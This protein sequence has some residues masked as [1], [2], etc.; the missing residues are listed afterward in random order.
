MINYIWSRPP[1]LK[2]SREILFAIKLVMEPLNLL[3]RSGG[4]Q[5]CFATIKHINILS[6]TWQ[7]KLLRN[8]R[9]WLQV[10]AHST[11]DNSTNKHAKQE[12]DL[13]LRNITYIAQMSKAQILDTT[14]NQTM[15]KWC[16]Q[17]GSITGSQTRDSVIEINTCHIK[18]STNSS[19]NW[20]WSDLSIL[21]ARRK[22][23]TPG[24]GDEGFPINVRKAFLVST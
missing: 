23:A 20:V 15:L 9:F 10:G 4:G 12:I 6:Y 11:H 5:T 21:L 16:L 7:L 24:G 2:S 19:Y 22:L 13:I 17:F 14:I 3:E 18:L 1:P 8:T